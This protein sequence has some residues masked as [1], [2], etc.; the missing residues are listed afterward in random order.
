MSH[1]I[2]GDISP[3]SREERIRLV[4]RAEKD[5]PHPGREAIFL[6][7]IIASWAFP[8]LHMV[9]GRVPLIASLI[10]SAD[11]WRPKR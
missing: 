10:E 1:S 8:D 5:Y 7:R 2:H 6:A 11:D 3:I 9:D 4:S